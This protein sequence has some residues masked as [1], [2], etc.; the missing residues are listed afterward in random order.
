MYPDQIHDLH[1]KDDLSFEG[2]SSAQTKSIKRFQLDQTQALYISEHC[3]ADEVR[4]LLK[5][6]QNHLLPVISLTGPLPF[7]VD[8]VFDIKVSNGWE[9][10]RALIETFKARREQLPHQAQT[11]IAPRTKL[12]AYLYVGNR[13]LRPNYAPHVPE[14]VTYGPFLP[15]ENPRALAEQLAGQGYLNRRYFDRF[16]LCGNCQSTRLNVREECTTCRSGHI[17]EVR[18]LHHL[19]CA[20]HGPETDFIEG[21]HLVCPKCRQALR[22]YGSDYETT[23]GMV[24]CCDCGDANADPAIGFKCMDCQTHADAAAISTIDHFEYELT[25]QG[26]DYLKDYDTEGAETSGVGAWG[27]PLAIAQDIQAM[28]NAGEPIPF[29][30]GELTY[31]NEAELTQEHGA[32][33]FARMRAQLL[34][35]LRGFLGDDGRV[36]GSRNADYVL[37]K[38]VTKDNLKP[39]LDV[40]V[41]DCKSTLKYD[42]GIAFEMFDEEGFRTR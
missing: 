33:A 21:E 16:H 39:H 17:E 14:G 12:L 2:G 42:P 27:L 24:R 15:V 28:T 23:G 38:G 29:V 5:Q 36:R 31:R 22:H 10:F 11:C 8:L 1:P 7:P 4:E 25:Q 30:L 35:N 26:I 13:T 19:S 41:E 32:R 40:L 6:E 18:V 37:F 34:E 9:E 3:T 20:C